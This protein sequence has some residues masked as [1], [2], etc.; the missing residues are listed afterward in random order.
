MSRI[1]HFVPLAVL[2]LACAVPAGAQP[3]IPP[4]DTTVAAGEKAIATFLVQDSVGDVQLGRLGLRKAHNAAVRALA[5]AMVADHTTTA[6]LGQSVAQQLGAED[7]ALK[8]ESTNQVDLAHLAR[9]SGSQFDREYVKTLVDAH[10]S[11]IGALNDALEFS[12]D[13]ALRSALRR[14]L[15]ID[16][17]HLRM[18]LAAQTA[19]GSGD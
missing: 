1:P 10:K 9:Y 15:A 11:D 16:Q 17:K 14:T 18:A 4:P 5:S 8:P 19:V 2:A 6:G 3:S 12:T 13:P 7:A